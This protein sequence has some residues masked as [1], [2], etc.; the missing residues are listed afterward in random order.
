MFISIVV[1][2]VTVRFQSNN[3]LLQDYERQVVSESLNHQ[4]RDRYDLNW[5]F[6]SRLDE[7]KHH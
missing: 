4:E 1:N 3:L 6:Q 2:F 5:W 7:R